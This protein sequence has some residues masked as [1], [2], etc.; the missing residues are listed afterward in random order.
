M[1][2]LS[3]AQVFD[4]AGRTALFQISHGFSEVGP[5]FPKHI[6][7][8]THYNL[9]TV[10]VQGFCCLAFQALKKPCFKLLP[11]HMVLPATLPSLPW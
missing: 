5:S 9:I 4:L 7:G 8:I 2:L 10:Q 11:A 6:A 3:Q 1:D